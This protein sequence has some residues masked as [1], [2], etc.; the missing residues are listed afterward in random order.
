MRQSNRLEFI[1]RKWNEGGDPQ[2]LIEQQS[3][4]FLF[5]WESIEQD[6]SIMSEHLYDLV[7]NYLYHLTRNHL[8]RVGNLT[9]R[10]DALVQLV[11]EF[12]SR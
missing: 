5:S 4:D 7:T 9:A 11:K 1:R 8:S 12:E 2:R 10:E 6:R 3:L